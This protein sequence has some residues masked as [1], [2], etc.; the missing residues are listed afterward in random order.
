MLKCFVIPS[1]FFTSHEKY[2]CWALHPHPQ[3]MTFFFVSD[4]ES[5]SETGRDVGLEHNEEG[6]LGCIEG[7]GA[8][9]LV[10]AV[11]SFC[12]KVGV[13]FD[14]TTQVHPCRYHS[15]GKI[16]GGFDLKLFWTK[17]ILYYGC[18]SYLTLS[19]T[20]KFIQ[21]QYNHEACEAANVNTWNTDNIVNKYW[22]CEDCIKQT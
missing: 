15:W 17:I 9:T 18:P 5:D 2:S 12:C 10:V 20:D 8:Q 3:H 22:A 1:N 14:H 4:I 6:S 16:F 19:Q 11:G 21:L 13:M 7:H